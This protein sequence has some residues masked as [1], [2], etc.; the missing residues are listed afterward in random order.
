[1]YWI[2]GKN[3]IWYVIFI[4]Y[5]MHNKYC[6]CKLECFSVN[7][8]VYIPAYNLEGGDYL[9]VKTVQLSLD[10]TA[11]RFFPVYKNIIKCETVLRVRSTPER[12]HSYSNADKSK[13]NVFCRIV[14]EVVYFCNKPNYRIL[15][16]CTCWIF[17][18]FL[19]RFWNIFQKVLKHLPERCFVKKSKWNVT[20]R[21]TSLWLMS[22]N[23]MM[24]IHKT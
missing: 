12:G 20:S 7:K 5:P 11:N 17:W 24:Y 18:N 13:V 10:Q 2:A 9:Q 19:C 21:I 6:L 1:M 16:R 23:D 15:S 3:F 22:H 4:I 14:L 8:K